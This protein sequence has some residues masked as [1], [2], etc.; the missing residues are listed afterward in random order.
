MQASP[1]GQ[2]VS[3]LASQSASQS[4][5]QSFSKSVGQLVSHSVSQQVSQSVISQLGSQSF[6]QYISWSA[7]LSQS[8]SDAGCTSHN[9]DCMSDLTHSQFY[10]SSSS[11]RK[12]WEL[13]TKLQ[14]QRQQNSNVFMVFKFQFLQNFEREFSDYK[15]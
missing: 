9:V 3:K 2:S 13:W 5:S 11:M 7:S 15:P 4:I 6:S 10:I 12:S 8:V 1:V 14:P